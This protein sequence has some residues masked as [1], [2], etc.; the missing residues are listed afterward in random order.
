M[1][2]L[3]VAL[4]AAKARVFLAALAALVLAPSAQGQTTATFDFDTGTPALSLYQNVP[5]DQTSSGLSAHFSA[6]SGGFSLQTDGTLGLSL[7]QFSGK[8]L[9]PNAAGSVLDIQF[10]QQLTNIT[11]TFAT[12]DAP[13]IEIP[14]P[15]VLIAYTNSA[16]ASAV[17]SVTNKA[18]YGSDSMP[19]GTLVFASAAQPFNRVRI[20]I[21]P[22]GGMG[23]LV[24]NIVVQSTGVNVYTIT[25][26][27][28]PGG[29]GST[30]GGGAY[31]SGASVTVVATAN[32]G[33]A[34]VN[35]TESGS[36]VSANA[37][38]G[39]TVSGNRTLVANFTPV[40]TIT[41]SASPVAGG[42]TSGG[43]V[44]N[45]GSNVTVVAT[46]NGGYAFVNWT[47]SGSPVSA[48]AS[49]SFTV[50]GNR[51]LVANFTNSIPQLQVWL[52]SGDTAVVAWPWPST[53]F[54]LQQTI[55]LSTTNSDWIDTTN[56]VNV[57]GGQKQVLVSLLSGN[58]IYRLVF[59]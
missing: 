44:Y 45:S 47:E 6:A 5:F 9:Y 38:Y 27:A 28:S 15:I 36:P 32:G 42:L 31:V 25:A 1:K 39:F 43:G 7:S 54:R 58:C 20:N 53:G 52:T 4:Y 12:A 48:N 56:T 59:P 30:S 29:G 24:D 46:A 34:F 18:T 13:P 37:S 19:M 57:V 3:F 10:S 35:W 22:G 49:Y 23:F 55:A 11:F 14:T 17:G 33:Y 8:Y 41:T 50:S 16:S 51:T 40:Y 26:S 21:Q 2:N